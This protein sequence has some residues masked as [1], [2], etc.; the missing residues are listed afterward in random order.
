MD[1]KLSLTSPCRRCTRPST[2]APMPAPQSPYAQAAPSTD[3][4]RLASSPGPC[5]VRRVPVARG[6]LIPPGMVSPPFQ[7]ER[8]LLATGTFPDPHVFNED[9][10][11][12]SSDFV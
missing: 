12:L 3:E 7:A 11:A 6:G 9:F 8:L 2:P 4:R 1:A 5:Q 10:A